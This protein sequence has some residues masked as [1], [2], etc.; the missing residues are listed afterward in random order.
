M[1][2]WWQIWLYATSFLFLLSALAFRRFWPTPSNFASMHSTHGPVK[3]DFKRYPRMLM[4]YNYVKILFTFSFIRI[5]ATSPFQKLYIS[6][7]QPPVSFNYGEFKLRNSGEHYRAERSC[8]KFSF[9]VGL[10]TFFCFVKRVVNHII[11]WSHQFQTKGLRSKRRNLVYRFGSASIPR[12]IC[13]Y[14]KEFFRI[15]SQTTVRKFLLAI[16][17]PR[18]IENKNHKVVADSYFTT[19]FVTNFV[20]I[21]LTTT[22]LMPL[23]RDGARIW[24]DSIANSNKKSRS[25]SCSRSQI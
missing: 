8:P 3:G 4:E 12:Y 25:R 13:C 2:V 17:M 10:H 6:P 5:L 11:V 24:R 15:D 14:R 19:W 7:S 16:H 21:L 18:C 22:I 23:V 20:V 1:H 9:N